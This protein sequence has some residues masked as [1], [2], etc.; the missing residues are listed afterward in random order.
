MFEL[1]EEFKN[2]KETLWNYLHHPKKKYLV[3]SK[4]HTRITGIEESGVIIPCP[5]ILNPLK[6]G[7][8]DLH[9]SIQSKYLCIPDDLP[10]S[11]MD[12]KNSRS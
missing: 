5:P 7:E 6:I 11:A 12:A 1:F 3:P 10:R 4:K 9:W 8:P 2:T